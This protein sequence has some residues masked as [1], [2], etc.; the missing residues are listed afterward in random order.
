M[1]DF[2]LRLGDG[3]LHL[4]LGHADDDLRLFELD[5]DG[6]WRLAHG[7]HG[8]R[9]AHVHLRSGLVDR[10]LGRGLFPVNRQ[11]RPL[12]PD[13]GR[14]V[15]HVNAGIVPTLIAAHVDQGVGLEAAQMA[16]QE[17]GQRSHV[18]VSDFGQQES[19]VFVGELRHWHRMAAQLRAEV[20]GGVVLAVIADAEIDNLA[21]M[22]SGG[23]HV[24]VLELFGGE[25]GDRPPMAVVAHP[26]WT[27]SFAHCRARHKVSSNELVRAGRLAK[28]AQV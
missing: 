11:R 25:M 16:F 10:D 26:P 5:G 28:G 7:D 8:P 9:L 6:R 4:G 13:L 19:V 18:A 21:G 17:H 2:H 24:A 3:Y 12:D 20:D 15:L 23:Q 14:S 27:S 22:P 1:F